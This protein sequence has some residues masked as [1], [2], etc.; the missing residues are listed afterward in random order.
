MLEHHA[1]AEL[2]G[3]GGRG[4]GDGLAMPAQFAR[5]RL[6][7]AIDDLDQRRLAGAVLA[8]ERMDLTRPHEERYIVIGAQGSEDLHNVKR[9]KKMVLADLVRHPPWP[10]FWL[11]V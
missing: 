9:F 8:K 10:F 2:A 1:D 7:S 4:N 11:I 5:R 3:G 6:Q